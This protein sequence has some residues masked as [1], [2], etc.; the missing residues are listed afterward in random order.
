MFSEHKNT[1]ATVTA[2][3]L[4]L[5]CSVGFTVCGDCTTSSLTYDLHTQSPSVKILFILE[6]SSFR[7]SPKAGL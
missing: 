7:K 1:I 3:I 4:H 6:R 2:A 5:E